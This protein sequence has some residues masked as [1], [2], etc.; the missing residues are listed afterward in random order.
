[1][2]KR[3]IHLIVYHQIW[4]GLNDSVCDAASWDDIIDA[5][6][7]AKDT[8]QSNKEFGLKRPWEK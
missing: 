3:V 1:M 5:L 6:E 2:S 4:R 7:A 8:A